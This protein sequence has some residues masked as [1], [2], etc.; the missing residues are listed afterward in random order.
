MLFFKKKATE[1]E[2][3]LSPLEGQLMPLSEVSDEAFSTGLMGSGF[4]IRPK[5]DILYMPF[6]G[7]IMMVFPTKHAV[8]MKDYKGSEYLIHIGVDTVNLNGLGFESF[9]HS[10]MKVKKGTRLIRF[11]LDKIQ[12]AGLDPVVMIVKTSQDEIAFD[13]SEHRAVHV[14]D[15]LIQL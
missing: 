1:T 4:A 5:N 7:E 2:Y 10:G 11:P 3:F 8:G 12:E 15:I 13:L 6:D 9:I 14:N